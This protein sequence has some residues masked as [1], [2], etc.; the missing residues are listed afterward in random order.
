MEISP[1]PIL[2]FDPIF[3][4]NKKGKNLQN[5]V[6]TSTKNDLHAFHVTLYLHE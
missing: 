4:A 3:K 5:G 2:F 6:V 1:K